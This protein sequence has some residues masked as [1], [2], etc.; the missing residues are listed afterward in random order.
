MLIEIKNINKTYFTDTGVTFRALS[1]ISTTF[2]DSGLVFILG[3]SG[4]GKSTLLNILGAL[5]SYDSGEMWVGDKLT[6][7]MSANMLDYYRNT[8]IGFVFQE[9]NLFNSLSVMENVKFAL[10]IKNDKDKDKI[11]NK[12]RVLDMLDKMGIKD[13]AKAKSRDLSGGQR[14]RVAIAR[15]LIKDPQII[16]ADE[17]TGSLDSVTGGEIINILS[18]ISKTKLVIVV[19]HD[20]QTAA[21]YGDRI[22]EMKDG[23]I[24]RDVRRR[25]P[26]ESIMAEGIDI[27]SNAI[28][29]INRDKSIDE[30]FTHRINEIITESG[31]KTY[32]NIETK[33]NRMKALF[34][35]LRD[36]ITLKASEEKNSKDLSEGED[37]SLTGTSEILKSDSFVP[38]V[39]K[40]AERKEVKF[41]SSRMAILSALKMGIHN[42]SLKKFRLI[43]IIIVTCISFTLFGAI[44]TLSS[45]D[46]ARAFAQSISHDEVK[47]ISVSKNYVYNSDSSNVISDSFLESLKQKHKHFNYYKQQF[48][49]MTITPFDYTKASLEGYYFNGFVGITEI[50]DIKN[51]GFHTLYGVSN[52]STKNSAVISS[53][54]AEAMIKAE[55]FGK[56]KPFLS[57]IIGRTVSVN[58]YEVVISGIYETSYEPFLGMESDVVVDV[59][60]HVF[61]MF[62]G[63][64]SGFLDSYIGT[65]S[66][67]YINLNISGQKSLDWSN[68]EAS[69]VY[70]NSKALLNLLN[71]EIID[72]PT[73]PEE[74][75][76]GIVLVLNSLTERSLSEYIEYNLSN[77]SYFN[78]GKNMS[79][80]ISYNPNYYDYQDKWSNIPSTKDVVSDIVLTLPSS[81]YYIKG[82]IISKGYNGIAVSEDLYNQYLNNVVKTRQILISLSQE[83]G[84]N[85]RLIRDLLDNDMQINAGFSFL[86]TIYMAIFLSF[87]T[88]IL[89]AVIFLSFL[90]ALLMYN[91]ISTSIR[92]TK[93]NIGLMRALG[94]KKVH[95]FLVYVLEGLVVAIITFVVSAIVLTSIIPIVNAAL[96]AQIG[97]YLPVMLINPNVFLLMGVLALAVSLL[98]TFVPWFKFAKITPIEAISNRKE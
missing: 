75:R 8:M 94:V 36:A 59:Y 97:F 65:Q 22:I 28:V 48:E 14:Q 84:Q 79:Y 11:S 81:K 24:F 52:P 15:A 93:R 85:M 3:K 37:E 80:N 38:Y 77:D 60:N 54:A 73:A 56:P 21:K 63:R 55:A 83:Q 30:H 50:D 66:K 40:N 53:Y 42:L 87:K 26:G 29:R 58:G 72:I 45:V 5:D 82:Y 89:G 61:Q 12:Q 10:D 32:L 7:S 90:A 16:L 6:K 76:E 86:F 18:E 35:N 91:F 62:V 71:N 49:N 23:A 1:N 95:T 33:E 31:R 2:D 67:S 74:S 68:N 43:M 51:L 4:S 17:P 98:A 19:T 47:T 78:L 57:D 39:P 44:N 20:V 64:D 41:Q 96:S 70:K 88:V 13:K 9:F 25:Q 34:P 69:F 27:V 46:T 92:L